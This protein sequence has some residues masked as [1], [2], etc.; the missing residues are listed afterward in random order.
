[1]INYYFKVIK[2]N[3]PDLKDQAMKLIEDQAERKIIKQ[4]IFMTYRPNYLTF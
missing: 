3:N 2:Y 4:Y 1:M